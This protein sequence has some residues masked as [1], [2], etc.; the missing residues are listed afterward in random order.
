M[1]KPIGIAAT[2]AHERIASG[3]ALLV[4]AYADEAACKKVDL[5]GSINLV[6]FGSRL[7]GL[8]TDQ[9]IIFYCA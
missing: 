5:E 6:Q 2:E 8:S 7:A 3:K 1:T 9:E 4:C